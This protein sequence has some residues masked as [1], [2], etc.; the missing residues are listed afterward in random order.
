MFVTA[1]LLLA[2]PDALLAVGRRGRVGAG[3]G[4]TSEAP[5]P[6]GDTTRGPSAPLA[7]STVVNAR[8]CGDVLDLEMWS[9]AE[10]SVE[11]WFRVV[12]LPLACFHTA[13]SACHASI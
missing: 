2:V 11:L 12:T 10:M 3:P 5:E 8:M 7:P 4:A 6:T 1:D 13:R 9:V